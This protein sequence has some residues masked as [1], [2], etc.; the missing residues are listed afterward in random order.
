MERGLQ[1]PSKVVKDHSENIADS[2][3]DP[4]EMDNFQLKVEILLLSHASAGS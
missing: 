3:A 1:S 2:N 4:A